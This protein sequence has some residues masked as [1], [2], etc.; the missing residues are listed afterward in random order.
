M[1]G[2]F[3]SSPIADFYNQ[4]KGVTVWKWLGAF[5]NDRQFWKDILE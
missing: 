1:P 3:L 4:V 2:H 5:V